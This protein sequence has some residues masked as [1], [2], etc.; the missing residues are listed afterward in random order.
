MANG[1]V[2]C[3]G[4]VTLHIDGPT[5]GT[6]VNCSAHQKTKNHHYFNVFLFHRFPFNQFGK[7]IWELGCALGRFVGTDDNRDFYQKWQ[8]GCDHWF[9]PFYHERKTQGVDRKVSE[10]KGDNERS[11]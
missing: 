7:A 5:M 11:E 9:Y 2:P 8:F 6:R 4:L 1:E 10:K 3:S